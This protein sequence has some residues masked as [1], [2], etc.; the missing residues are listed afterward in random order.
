MV[1]KRWRSIAK[2]P[3]FGWVYSPC[4][5]H[6]NA[7]LQVH[8]MTFEV[9]VQKTED[10]RNQ[11][12]EKGN[13]NYFRTNKFQILEILLIWKRER[14]RLQPNGITPMKLRPT[15]YVFLFR[16]CS[17]YRCLIEKERKY[18]CVR[19]MESEWVVATTVTMGL[20]RNVCSLPYFLFTLSFSIVC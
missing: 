6:T 16:C 14:Q 18:Q 5:S 7:Y 15:L 10:E 9:R 1:C 19:W 12:I 20:G 4:W 8:I 3:Y 2:D 17:C 11:N 13:P